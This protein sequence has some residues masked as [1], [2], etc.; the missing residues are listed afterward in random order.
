MSKDN[1]RGMK[2]RSRIRPG[3][4][5]RISFTISLFRGNYSEELRFALLNAVNKVLEDF[6]IESKCDISYSTVV[7]LGTLGCKRYSVNV[8]DNDILYIEKLGKT[9]MI[10]M[11]DQTSIPSNASLKA[12]ER[13]LDHT[14]FMRVHQGYIVNIN[15]VEKYT[16]SEV[17]LKGVDRPIPLSR[18]NR[19]KLN[20]R[21]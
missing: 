8:I 3:R 6:N 14:K 1:D 16:N 10:R 11:L 12:M 2:D 13:T 17:F 9:V 20:N 21:L 19:S 5:S 18:R 7:D 4:R 15:Y